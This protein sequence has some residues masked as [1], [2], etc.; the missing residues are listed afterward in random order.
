MEVIPGS[1]IGVGARWGAGGGDWKEEGTAWG[2]GV[3]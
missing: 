1:G 3:A 2:E